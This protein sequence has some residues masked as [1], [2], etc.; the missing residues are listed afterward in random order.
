MYAPYSFNGRGPGEACAAILDNISPDDLD[1]KLYLGR[2]RRATRAHVQVRAALPRSVNRVPWRMVEARAMRRLN[3]QFHKALLAADPERTVAYFWPD[4]PIQ[5]VKAARD[6]DLPVVREMIN[7]ACATSRPILDGAYERLGLP[8]NH[9][10]TDDKI[11]RENEELALCD[12]VFASNPE[13][14]SSLR[15]AGV[16]ESRILAT[17]FGWRPERFK[18]LQAAPPLRDGVRVL[19]VGSVSVRKGVPELLEA[20]RSSEVKGE[21][22][23]A[24]AVEPSIVDLV[25]AQVERGGVRHLGFVEDVG[26]LYRGSD[27]F[28]FPTLEEGGPQVTYEAAGCGLPVITTP[29]GAARLVNTGETGV[30]VNHGS[31]P[32]LSA[33]LSQ[34]ANDRE[35]RHRY[36]NAARARAA[37]FDY[38][39]VGRQRGSLLRQAAINY[40][41][42]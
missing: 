2:T 21:L 28:A 30:V 26:A 23:L 35:L 11:Q 18:S 36:G 13:V 17:S 34:L 31:V 7:S 39:R 24:G 8:A 25:A 22:V 14:E 12:F 33:A 29:M 4:P 20:W 38:R 5:L 32:E 40:H 19:F 16:G 9:T 15:E 1:V 41:Q 3:Q 10:V 37:A 6:H 42:R 27:I